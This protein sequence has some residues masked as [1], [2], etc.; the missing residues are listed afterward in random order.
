MVCHLETDTTGK[1][2]PDWANQRVFDSF[3]EF[4]SKFLWEVETNNL[5]PRRWVW[6]YADPP[7]SYEGC[8]QKHEGA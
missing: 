7:V 3:S 8:P 1:E 4:L 5:S 2:I 6:E